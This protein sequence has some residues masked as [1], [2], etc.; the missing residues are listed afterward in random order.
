M[1]RKI[2]SPKFKFTIVLET[3]KETET[4]QK[5]ASKHGIVPSQISCWVIIHYQRE[6]NF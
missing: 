4:L 6:W 3:F 1:P 2:Y 5:I